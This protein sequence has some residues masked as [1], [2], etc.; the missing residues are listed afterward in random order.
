MVLTDLGDLPAARISHQKA[1]TIWKEIGDEPNAAYDEVALAA[2]DLEEGRVTPKIE[3]LKDAVRRLHDAE[4]TDNE[5]I[6][7]LV[8]AEVLAGQRE[9]SQ[10]TKQIGEVASLLG[11]SEDPDIE[12][13]FRISSARVFLAAGDSKS[14]RRAAGAALAEAR[15]RG[16]VGREL[17]ARLLLAELDAKERRSKLTTLKEDAT[18]KKFGLIAKKCSTLLASLDS[19]AERAE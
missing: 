7:R 15:R 4:E 19:Q 11:K 18:A 17:A 3:V 16:Y 9:T 10:A 13:R 5:I 6:A 12:T 8:L 14:A 1:L 2:L